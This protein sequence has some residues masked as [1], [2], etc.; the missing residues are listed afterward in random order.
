[1]IASFGNSTLT[2]R[3]KFPK[4]AIMNSTNDRV[5]IQPVCAKSLIVT[6]SYA[7]VY[8]VE[9]LRGGGGLGWRLWVVAGGSRV[10]RVMI[11]R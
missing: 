10:G 7:V 5:H 2:T 1:M 6:L 4:I 9:R 3:V 8:S 11:A